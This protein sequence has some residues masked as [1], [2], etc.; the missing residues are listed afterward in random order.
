MKRHRGLF[1]RVV[2]TENLFAAARAA[3]RGKK[4]KGAAA[5]CFAELEKVVFRLKAELESGGWTPGPAHY[6]E[7]HEPK[8][9]EVAAAPFRD[10]IVHHAVVRVLEPIF[11]KRFIRDSYACRAGKGTHAGVARAAQYARRYPYHLKCDIRKYFPHI[12]HEL[13]RAAL[14]RAVNDRRLMALIDRILAAHRDG[15]AQEWDGTG[16]LFAVRERV[17]GLPIGN[18]TS[19]FFANI[20]LHAL[21]LFVK[22]TLRVKGYVRYVDDFL[23]YG[24]DPAA[25]RR[26]GREVRTFLR[27]LR[28]EIH[29]DK[30]RFGPTAQ[31]VDFCGFVVFPD[32]RVRLRADAVRRFTRRLRAQVHAVKRG[33]ME[34]ADLQK[35]TAGWIAHARSAQSVRLRAAIFSRIRFSRAA[36]S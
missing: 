22:E 4:R 11:E 14:A 17:R 35:R 32:G 10:R 16:D 8:R 9:R 34:L 3:M 18:L 21:D 23:L 36:G 7:I 5:R 12:D 33:R 19:Q 2:A 30:Y 6:F 13:L 29:P 24:D 31:G 1:E 28:L 20:H 26:Q 27:G 25:L 15:V